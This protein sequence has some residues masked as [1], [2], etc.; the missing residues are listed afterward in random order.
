[1]VRKGTTLQKKIFA[2]E[3]NTAMYTKEIAEVCTECP[4]EKCVDT[5]TGCP[6]WKAAWKEAMKTSVYS[7]SQP[8]KRAVVSDQ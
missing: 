4:Y 7:T 5:N 3:G 6:R 1:V 8:R 2:G